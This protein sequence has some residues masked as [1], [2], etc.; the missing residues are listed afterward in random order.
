MPNHLIVVERN[1]DKD[2][3]AGAGQAVTMREYVTQPG[4][5]NGRQMRVVNLSSDLGYMDLGYYVSL[6]AEARGQK[7][8][9]SVGTIIDL[10]RKMLYSVELPEV[11]VILRT[12]LEKLAQPPK[13]GF[14]L[15]ICFGQVQ[16]S[17][18]KTLAHELFDRFRC[19]LVRV[20]IAK[21]ERWRVDS[22]E[23]LSPAKLSPEEFDFFLA[24]L[25]GY[26]KA[27]W[28]R[29]KARQQPRYSLAILQNPNE[30]LPPSSAATLKRF[31]TI[32]PSIGFAVDL[33]QR[34]DYLRLAEYDALFIRETTSIDNHTYRFAKKARH[35]GMPVI[36]DP[37]SMLRCTNK[38][39][40]AELLQ[41]NK[42]SAPRT[43][44]VDRPQ[45]LRVEE[46]IGYPVVLKI[47]DGSFSR[48]VFKAEDRAQLTEVSR[49][50]FQRSA[51]ILAQEFMYTKY[52]WR[53]GVLGKQPLFVSQYFMTR[54]H[55]Q[56]VHHYKDGRVEEGGFKTMAVE[57]A[58]R[59]VVEL[60]V[61]A[62]NLIG[63]GLYGVDIKQ[64]GT[65]VHV[66]EINDN[67][68]LDKG[69]E[70]AILKDQLYQRVLGE[71]L[72]RVEAR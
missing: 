49:K 33:I 36:D 24:A 54:K 5:Y 18:F 22:L 59:E 53:V 62:A 11:N 40:L 23:A 8:V 66:I 29:P 32:G 37:Q 20:T 64:T 10:T 13:T 30:A 25:E 4:L 50:L 72:R 57:D 19:P 17:R 65:G 34:K 69:V 47:P 43:I 61:K 6:L 38:V 68:N 67:P 15:V 51:V 41:S 26:T 71:F 27:E 56:I 58:P 1:E 52:D 3:A 44:I 46:E 14:S 42:L 21:E 60:G 63:D 16:D 2:W 28:R 45:L 35:E 48:G 55:W 39:Y 7:V 70:D 9:P 31:Q 12:T